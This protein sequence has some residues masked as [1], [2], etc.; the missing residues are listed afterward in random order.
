VVL[1]D[2]HALLLSRNKP[3]DFFVIASLKLSAHTPAQY[4]T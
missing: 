4:Y 3:S 1:F 2:S